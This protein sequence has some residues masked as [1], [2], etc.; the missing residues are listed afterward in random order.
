[1]VNTQQIFIYFIFTLFSSKNNLKVI[2]IH[3]QKN[4]SFI[5]IMKIYFSVLPYFKYVINMLKLGKW[6]G[7]NF[8]KYVFKY[9]I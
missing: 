6:N 7:A 2:W 1:M 9:C 5:K 4:N 8:L 3:V